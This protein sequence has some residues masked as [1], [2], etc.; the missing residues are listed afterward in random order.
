MAIKKTT[1]KVATEDNQVYDVEIL[2]AKDLSKDG[3]TSIALDMKVNGVKI[4]SCWYRVYEDRKKPGEEKGFIA[5]P[6]RQGSDGNWYQY[7]W[8]PI[9][10]ELL[11][12]L[13]GQIEKKLAEVD[14]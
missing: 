6:S 12:D 8:F 9:S 5:F 3:K 4:Y 14:A 7:A 11:K 13:E 10:E 1:K 2:R